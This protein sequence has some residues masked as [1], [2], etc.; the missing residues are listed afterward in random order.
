M[1]QQVTEAIRG[2]LFLPLALA[3]RYFARRVLCHGLWRYS[4]PIVPESFPGLDPT[5]IMGLLDRRLQAAGISQHAAID[6]IRAAGNV[7]SSVGS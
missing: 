4:S 3:T 5:R 2:F 7:G 1:L 6:H